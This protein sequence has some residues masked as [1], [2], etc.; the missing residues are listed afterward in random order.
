M[1][2]IQT[3]DCHST[4]AGLISQLKEEEN[5][6]TQMNYQEAAPMVPIVGD[7]HPT[8]VEDPKVQSQASHVLAHSNN[9]LVLD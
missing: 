8:P 2:C 5:G 7:T 3:V 1:V 9:D 6:Q 4:Q